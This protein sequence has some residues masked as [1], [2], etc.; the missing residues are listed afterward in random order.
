MLVENDDTTN[1]KGEEPRE[2]AYTIRGSLPDSKNNHFQ[3]SQPHREEGKLTP[4]PAVHTVPRVGKIC[5]LGNAGSQKLTVLTTTG[6]A[7]LRLE[8][9]E[10]PLNLRALGGR[11][12][13]S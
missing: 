10:A 7:S 4:V 2:T 6:L 13:D 11:P 5:R 3:P 8:Q 1:N 12:K 9:R